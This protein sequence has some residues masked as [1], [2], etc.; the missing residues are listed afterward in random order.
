MAD[1]ETHMGDYRRETSSAQV[2]HRKKVLP[3]LGATSAWMLPLWQFYWNQMVFCHLKKKERR[4]RLSS[5]GKMFLLYTQLAL[6]GVQFNT[7]TPQL[8]MWQ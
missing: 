2:T 6:A 4:R 1:K 8:S 5:V 3:A 7:M